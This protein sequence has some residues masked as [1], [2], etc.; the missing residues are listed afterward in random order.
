M[1]FGG[2]LNVHSKRKSII[3]ITEQ[4]LEHMFIIHTEIYYVNHIQKHI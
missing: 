2:G 4:Q 3:N 1:P